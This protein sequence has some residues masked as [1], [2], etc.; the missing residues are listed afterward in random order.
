[1]IIV[2]V[3]PGILFPPKK[4]AVRRPGSV[5]D[6]GAVTRESV[7]TPT[8]V[9][10]ATARPAARS[11]AA[12]AA[13]VWVTSPLYRLGFTTRGARLVRGELLGYRSFAAGDS[14]RSV[15]LVPDGA[16]WLEH[17]LA[18]GG[19]GGGGGDTVA[20]SEL[21]CRPS[22]AGSGAAGDGTPL[23]RA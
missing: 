23:R 22:G 18:V 2:A 12:P 4:S 9:P 1:M 11:T 20:L 6:S 17:R 5:T 8:R 14:S 19:G 7:T 16:A 13:T 10:V 15:Q 3:V 21:E